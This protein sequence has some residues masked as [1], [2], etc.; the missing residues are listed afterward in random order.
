MRI[1]D[2]GS[3]KVISGY[4]ISPCNPATRNADCGNQKINSKPPKKGLL[5]FALRIV[6]EEYLK[7]KTKFF[8]NSQTKKQGFEEFFY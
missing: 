5:L 1:V 4:K 2:C 6:E 7:E 3:N 8:R